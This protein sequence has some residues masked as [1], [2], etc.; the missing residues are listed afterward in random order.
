MKDKVKKYAL[1]WQAT[2]YGVQYVE[3]FDEKDAEEQFD[4]IKHEDAIPNEPIYAEL[5]E[6]VLVVESKKKRRRLGG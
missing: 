6:V 4:S 2:V 5:D 3:A 1:Y